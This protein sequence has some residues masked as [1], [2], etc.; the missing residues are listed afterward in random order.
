MSL[1]Q[2]QGGVP[3]HP[4]PVPGATAQETT[5]PGDHGPGGHG[6]QQAAPR[7][8]VSLTHAHSCEF[9][10]MGEQGAS[11]CPD[12]GQQHLP[13]GQQWDSGPKW[14]AP[15]VLSLSQPGMLASPS[16]HFF[17]EVTLPCGGSDIV[18]T[19]RQNIPV[20]FFPIQ[21]ALLVKREEHAGKE[22][23]SSFHTGRC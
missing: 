17:C 20:T 21:G 12:L 7:D 6:T 18:T 14:Q 2:L 1:T 15:S 5:G 3:L 8:P 19:E 4:S 11:P 9:T 23:T 10:H 22:E 13:A 16:R